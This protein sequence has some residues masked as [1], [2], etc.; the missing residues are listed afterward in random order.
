MDKCPCKDCVSFAICNAIVKKFELIYKTQHIVLELKLKCTLIRDW[1]HYNY[2]PSHDH[3]Y[4]EFTETY[5][6]R[7][8]MTPDYHL[9]R[10]LPKVPYV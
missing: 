10:N 5:N 1:F 9:L 3:G 6:I 2:Y 8:N 7:K 4:E